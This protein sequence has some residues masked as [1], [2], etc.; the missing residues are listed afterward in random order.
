MES[1]FYGTCENFLPFRHKFCEENRMKKLTTLVLAAGLV[2]SAFAG[3]A[4]AGEFKPV[5]Q[6]AEEFTYVDGGKYSDE[7][8][9]AATRIRFGFDYIA[10]EDLSVKNWR[11]E[12]IGRSYN[13][14]TTHTDFYVRARDCPVDVSQTHTEVV[15]TANSINFRV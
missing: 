11:T 13:W 8:F 14:L 6:F 9:N 1:I 4:S 3:S 12:C 7:N 2:V 15:A 10:S 5:L